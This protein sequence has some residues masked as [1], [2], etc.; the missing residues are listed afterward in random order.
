MR[1]A[2]RDRRECKLGCDDLLVGKTWLR[3]ETFRCFDGAQPDCTRR[4]NVVSP[5]C[6]RFATSPGLSL[7][8]G[9]VLAS[10][11]SNSHLRVDIWL[12]RDEREAERGGG[13]FAS[14]KPRGERGGI[15]HF[16]AGKQRCAK[17]IYRNSRLSSVY[18]AASVPLLLQR[19]EFIRLVGRFDACLGELD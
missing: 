7:I 4:D 2:K 10:S 19:N 15:D 17:R 8:V 18:E 1:E 6:F 16:H 9:A 3:G 12:G 14:E 11:R 13:S 5:I